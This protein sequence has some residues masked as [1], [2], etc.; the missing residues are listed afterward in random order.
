MSDLEDRLVELEI[1]VALQDDLL[2]ELN[3]TI[4]KMR[5]TLDL[6]QEQLRLLYNKMQQNQ[7]THTEKPYSLAE[8]VP[9]HY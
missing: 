7:E 8:E 6:Q 3:H 2:D 5:E 9:P 1:R 4:V